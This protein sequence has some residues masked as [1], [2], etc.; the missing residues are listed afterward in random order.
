[1][2]GT[3]PKGEGE[4]NC[5]SKADRDA[6]MD[7]AIAAEAG[8]DWRVRRM[9]AGLAGSIGLHV[10]LL[11]A[12]FLFT[13]L[14][15]FVVPEPPTITVD[16]IPMSAFEPEPAVP[17]QLDLDA[18]PEVG[19]PASAESP[20]GPRAAPGAPSMGAD[21]TFR[22]TKLYA[23]TLLK[24]PSMAAV[25]RGLATLASSEKVMQ[26][27]SIE[28]LEQIRLAA[29]QYVPD[30]MVSYA[31]ADPV[32]TGLMLTA[33]GG[34]FRSRRLWYVVSFE[35]VASPSL[36]GVASFSFK[37]GDAIARDQWEAHFLNA[38]DADE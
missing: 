11:A 3:A 20:T 26:L 6:G 31:M 18:P 4:R 19:D 1:M 30:T 24:E 37:L 27:C 35:C 7:G 34:A 14:R 9:P 21:G 8:T 33:M 29:P 17:P 32:Q 10:A 2:A 25:R 16:L 13:P 36:D 22:A 5:A 23:A 15:T 12:L 38:E 28:A